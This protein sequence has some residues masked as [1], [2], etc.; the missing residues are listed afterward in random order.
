MIAGGVAEICPRPQLPKRTTKTVIYLIL[1]FSSYLISGY[2]KDISGIERGKF[3]R[4]N[5]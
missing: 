3:C 4:M 1:F 2:A 5:E